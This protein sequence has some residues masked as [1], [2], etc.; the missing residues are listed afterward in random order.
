M[1]IPTMQTNMYAT[2]HQAYLGKG[3]EML[4]MMEATKA[5]NQA[6]WHEGQ[7]S[8]ECAGAS[9]AYQRDGDGSQRKRVT[10]DVAEIDSTASACFHHVVFLQGRGMQ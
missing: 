6:S 5:I 2:V 8:Y 10:D 1:V 7:L 9:H 3:S 4:A